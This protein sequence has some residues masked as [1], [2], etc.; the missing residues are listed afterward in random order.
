[1]EPAEIVLVITAVLVGFF[2]KGVTGIG[3]PLLIVPVLAGVMGLEFAVTVIAIPTVIAN[4][5]LLWDTRGSTLEVAW[6]LWPLLVAGAVGTVIGAWVLLNIDSRVMTLALAAIILAYIVW[7]LL[8][9]DFTLSPTWA[10][11]LSAPAGLLGGILQGG[12]GAS[13]P[14]IGTYVHSLKLERAAFVLA[15]TIPFQILGIVQIVSLAL[16]G[17]YNQDRLIA[18]AIATVPALLAMRPA[19]RLGDRLSQR[20]FQNVVLAVLALAALRLIW[21]AV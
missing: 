3:A 11:R 17:G 13:G 21:I 19:M 20:T 8:N 10:K 4:T 6:F 14:V 18:A 7:S 16:F 15:V 9:K 2:L 5:W 12:T 1:M